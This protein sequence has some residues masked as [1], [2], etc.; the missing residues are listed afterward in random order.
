M[1]LELR[2]E[3]ATAILFPEYGG[4]LHQLFI[5]AGGVDEPLLECP[6]DPEHYL[7]E[8][9]HGGSFPMAPWPNRIRDGA[10]DWAGAR[11]DVPREGKPHAIHGRVYTAP[12]KVTARTARVCEM[13][14]EFDSGWPWAGKAW[15]RYELRDTSL[16]M[17][18]EVRS[19]REPFPAGCGWHPWF[20]RDVAG[21]NDVHLKLPA[22]RRYVLDEHLPTNELVPLDDSYD[23]RDDFAGKRRIDDCYTGL[24]GPIELNWGRVM[25]Q[26]T[27]DCAFPHVQVY[28]PENAICIEPQT[29][30]PDAF[31]LAARGSV[32][33]GMMIA[34]PGK[35]VGISSE[36]TWFTR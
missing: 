5:Q 14:V 23:V 10:F 24:L 8:P 19:F 1:P 34:R 22:T 12:W 30:A 33:D 6:L 20:R 16:L 29:C 13:E 36:W 17:K 27:I 35:A 26:V 25:L 3:G 4:R 21:A 2:A 18:M 28:T 31:N 11:Y 9:T 7:V 15:Q 32:G